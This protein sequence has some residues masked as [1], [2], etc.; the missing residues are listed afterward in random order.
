MAIKGTAKHDSVKLRGQVGG[1]LR[2]Y[3]RG[4]VH[5]P[6]IVKHEVTVRVENIGAILMLERCGHSLNPDI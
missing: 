4:H 1:A 3:E 5:D 2:G 6:V